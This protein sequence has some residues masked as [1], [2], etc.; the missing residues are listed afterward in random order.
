VEESDEALPQ[1]VA[2]P[3]KDRP[4]LA[5][6]IRAGATYLLTGDIHHFGEYFGRTFGGV[7]ILPRGDYLGAYGRGER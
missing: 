1:Q 5:A 6:A 2:L 3:A 7:Q 4:I